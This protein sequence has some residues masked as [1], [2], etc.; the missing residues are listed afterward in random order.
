MRGAT[1]G[2]LAVSNFGET[3]YGDEKIINV[4]VTDAWVYFRP[5]WVFL[6]SLAKMRS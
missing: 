5:A 1:E 3:R 4:C 6:G 2:D